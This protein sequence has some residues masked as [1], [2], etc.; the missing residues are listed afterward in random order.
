MP[1]QSLHRALIPGIHS[2]RSSQQQPTDRY[3]LIHDID[4]TAAAD[5]LM[6]E[7]G[8]ILLLSELLTGTFV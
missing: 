3:L 5:W 2:L 7:V 4:T 8:K 1:V 6:L